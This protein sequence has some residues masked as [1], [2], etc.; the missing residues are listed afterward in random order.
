MSI[1]NKVINRFFSILFLASF[2]IAQPTVGL[3]TPAFG[4]VG[5][6]IIING[7][8]FSPNDVGNT[9]FF[10]GLEANTL[11]STENEII[12]SVPNGAYYTPISV[13]TNGLYAT[14][15]QRFNVTFN[16]TEE[17]TVAHLSN[18]LDNPYLGAKYY[19]IKIADLNGDEILEIVTSEAGSG[20]SAYLAIF[21]TSFDDEG[22][23][24]IDDRLEINFGTGVYSA[25]HDIALGDLNGDGLLDIVASEKGDVTDDF[26]AHTCIFI[27]SS[28]NQNF[29]F[30]SPIII[31]A[32][33]YESCVQLQ[34][35]NGD[36]KLD[37]VTTRGT[38]DQLG[39][40]VNTSDGNSVSFA[41]KVIIS[42]VLANGR[43]DFA[44]LNGDGMIDMVT[45][46]YSSSSYSNREVFV[47]SNN[48]AEGN[49]EFDLEATIVAGGFPPA[50][51]NDYNWSSSNPTLADIDGD[52]R[53]DIIVGNGTCGLCSP[54]GISILRNISTDSE[55]GFEYEYSDF[56]QYESNS[57]PVGISIS[58]LNGD[59]KPDLLTNDW[60]GGISIMVNSSTEGNISLEEQ[61][62][63]GVGG[64]PLSIATADLNMDFT[65]EIVV[66]N[67]EVE[68]LRIIHN[69]LPIDEQT[70][71]LLYDIN[72]D[73]LV[74]NFDFAMLLSLVI[75]QNDSISTADI[76][77]DSEVD[78]F[79]LL[80]LSD[81]LQN[82]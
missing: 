49:I 71:D 4:G 19:D 77:F 46:S 45:A 57:L 37:I 15:S 5:S 26:E 35:I 2:I 42:N 36:G 21:T 38:Y 82:M 81:F 66:A 3:I 34:D 6:T 60:M 50:G 27:N 25:P 20:S 72:D 67:W 70:E 56:Y 31:S 75:N 63:I 11:N 23:I 59:G 32:D 1:M 13:Y 64:F 54:S 76:N 78:I 79:D 51:Y 62:Q 7:S 12:V 80:L 9:V 14:S 22:M 55:L 30:E 47:Y 39:V 58:D 44:D 65:P 29:S 74:N 61:M 68:G 24:S 43:P 33:G 40:Y 28:Q 53:L 18:Q 10:G 69:F 52:G 73:G 41:D 8:N 17:L 16:A 48:S